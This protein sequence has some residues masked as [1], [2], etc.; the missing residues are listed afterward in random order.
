MRTLHR[1]VELIDRLTDRLGR[2]LA[3]LCLAMALVTGAIVL[4][5]YGF[6][7]GSIALQESVTYMHAAMFTLGAAY[8]LKR[9]G[10]V[11]V[12]IFYRRFSARGRAWVNSLGTVVFLLPFSLFLFA[13]SWQFVAGSWAVREG[14]PNPGGIHAVF[15]LKALLPLLALNLLLQGSAELLRNGLLLVEDDRDGG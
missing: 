11:R 15:L 7:I 12:D 14:S 10:H 2:A 3:W 8:T 9:N 1:T 4:L 5:R 6:G 13:V